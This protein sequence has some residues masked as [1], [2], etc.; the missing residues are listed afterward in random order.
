MAM[1][2]HLM[3]L[4]FIDNR[5]FPGGPEAYELSVYSTAIALTPNATFIIANW[6]ADG[7]L[8][9]ICSSPTSSLTL[10]QNSYTAI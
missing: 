6:L 7:L 4:A 8:V 9:G 10:M 3:Q 5:N 1:N 2:V